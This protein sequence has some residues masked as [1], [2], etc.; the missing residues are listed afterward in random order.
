[1]M[2]T[3]SPL[4][5]SLREPDPDTPPAF[6]FVGPG[7]ASP[8]RGNACGV[9]GVPRGEFRGPCVGERA[10]FCPRVGER[11][12]FCPRVDTGAS[13]LLLLL[14]LLLFSILVRPVETTTTTATTDY[15]RSPA[16]LKG[17]D[18][19]TEPR[20]GGARSGGRQGLGM[21][22]RQEVDGEGGYGLI[23]EYSVQKRTDLTG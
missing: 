10:L 23:W 16:G 9:G 19:S 22:Y 17:R 20:H 12:R 2:P 6:T 21:A 14:L 18:A 1:M 5:P 11:A 7:W 3:L 15:S 8:V 4:A 13:V